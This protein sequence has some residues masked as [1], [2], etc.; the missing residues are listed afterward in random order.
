MFL[1]CASV[2]HYVCSCFYLVLC[3]VELDVSFYLLLLYIR[4]VASFTSLCDFPH[5]CGLNIWLHTISSRTLRLHAITWQIFAIVFVSLS[6]FFVFLV[7]RLMFGGFYFA[8]QPIPSCTNFIVFCSLFNA[9]KLNVSVIQYNALFCVIPKLFFI[10][11]FSVLH[12]E[13]LYKFAM[14]A[15]RYFYYSMLF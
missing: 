9:M 1:V 5:D 2:V 4:L 8:I 10:R 3:T 12:S 6:I 7:I 11:S 14:H 15:P 13:I